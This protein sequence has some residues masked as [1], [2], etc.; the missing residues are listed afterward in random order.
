MHSIVYVFITVGDKTGESRGLEVPEDA[1]LGQFKRS[2]SERLRDGA[3]AILRRMESIKNSKKKK[4]QNRDGVVISSPKVQFICSNSKSKV[5]VHVMI[6]FIDILDEGVQILYYN[7]LKN[8]DYDSPA[9]AACL[10]FFFF[11]QFLWIYAGL[12]P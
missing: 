7:A 11:T 4:R 1:L 8:L 9:I 10:V 5:Y 2:G 6:S 3:K 12:N